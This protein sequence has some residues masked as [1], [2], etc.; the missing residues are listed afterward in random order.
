M[1]ENRHTT[2]FLWGNKGKFMNLY[3]FEICMQNVQLVYIRKV[4]VY[5]AQLNTHAHTDK[6]IKP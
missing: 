1:V 2:E 5:S 3:E 6:R 4:M